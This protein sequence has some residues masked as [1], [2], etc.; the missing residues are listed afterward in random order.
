MK[1]PKLVIALCASF[2]AGILATNPSAKAQSGGAVVAPGSSTTSRPVVVDTRNLCNPMRGGQSGNGVLTVAADCYLGSIP[3]L[4]AFRF[5]FLNS[6]HQFRRV[7]LMPQGDN[8]QA[9][10]ADDGGEDPFTAE[11]QWWRIPEA[12]GGIVQGVVAGYADLY[13][14]EG[15]PNSTLVLSGFEFRRPDGTDRNIRTIAINTDSASRRIRVALLDDNGTDYV[16]LAEAVALGFAFGGISPDP[17]STL[18]GL[19]VSS[20]EERMRL[21]F[22]AD[23]GVRFANVDD[24]SG[25][26]R[27]IPPVG[28]ERSDDSRER[29]A[30][31]L[32][33]DLA[34]QKDQ[35]PTQS[36]IQPNLYTEAIRKAPIRGGVLNSSPTPTTAPEQEMSDRYFDVEPR[37]SDRRAAPYFVKVAYIWAPNS[38]LAAGRM[39]SGSSR[40]AAQ[41]S[42]RLPTRPHVLQ[43]FSFHFGNSD[44]FIRDFGVH[45]TGAGPVLR[46]PA[47]IGEVVS[48]QD[49]DR[50]DPIQWTV[51]FS[52]LVG[53]RYPEVRSGTSAVV[54]QP[55]KR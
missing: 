14:P 16:R 39:V 19:P 7:T 6:N 1:F 43:G 50:D 11:G 3:A 15:P 38:R 44:H 55:N 52:D 26:E 29:V 20:Q 35:P 27:A 40:A 22:G 49:D 9:A 33:Q 17:V 2:F 42:G 47:A 23:R 30:G 46:N 13:V 4:Q 31:R 21:G 5:G 54:V 34:R 25:L 53:Y 37:V 41:V 36:T 24:T 8:F 45:L 48:W 32:R 28:E 12:P 18:G 51:R 10:F